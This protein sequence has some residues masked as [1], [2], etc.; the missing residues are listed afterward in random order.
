MYNKLSYRKY[1]KGK[2][3][4]TNEQTGADELAQGV[5]ELTLVEEKEI[6][7]FFKNF[8]IKSDNLEQLKD[9][10]KG[11]ILYREKVL[12]KHETKFGQ[13]YPMYF[14][15]SSLV[16]FINSLTNSDKNFCVQVYI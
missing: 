16:R 10:M 6:E 2:A 12:K 13:L 4:V 9:K 5:S 3:K 14:L 8:V 11:T 15:D 1:G 7:L